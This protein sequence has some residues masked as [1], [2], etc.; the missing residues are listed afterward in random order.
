MDEEQRKELTTRIRER[1]LAAT[2]LF[3]RMTTE[4]K[5]RKSDRVRNQ[6][7][8]ASRKISDSIAKIDKELDKI[9]HQEKVFAILEQDDDDI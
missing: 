9:A 6:M 4:A 7:D 3:L 2:A 5:N 1:R 8:I